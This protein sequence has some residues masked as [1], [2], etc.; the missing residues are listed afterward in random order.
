MDIIR[1]L[2]FLLP[3]TGKLVRDRDLP[4]LWAT[5]LAG[6]L[7]AAAGWVGTCYF[8]RLWNRQY[9]LRFWHHLLCGAAAVV[10]LLVVPAWTVT[11]YVKSTVEAVG[12]LWQQHLAA[13]EDWQQQT[14]ARAYAAV[15]RLGVEDFADVPP[16]GLPNSRIP[17]T[18]P[19]SVQTVSAIYASGAVAHFG[20]QFPRLRSLVQD[21][22]EG[23]ALRTKIRLAFETSDAVYPVEQAGRFAA[24]SIGAGVLDYVLRWVWKAHLVLAAL[25][26]GAQALAFGTTSVAAYRDIKV[27]T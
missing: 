8:A 14:F 11:S 12:R 2:F 27:H 1:D 3:E 21:D 9:R 18:N 24:A 7:L 17:L 25:F 13:D 5:L 26:L 4:S 23:A 16:P 15:Q 20:A 22:E 6:L 10:T 19:V